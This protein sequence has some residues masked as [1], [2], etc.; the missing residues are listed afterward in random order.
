MW[1]GIGIGGVILWTGL[2]WLIG[3]LMNP[4]RPQTA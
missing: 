3:A 4:A 1:W 2:L